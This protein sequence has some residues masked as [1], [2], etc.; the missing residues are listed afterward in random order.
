MTYDVVIVGGGPAGLQA[1]LT[2]GRARKRVLLCDA[3]PR[4]N[5]AAEHVHNFVTRD[6]TPPDELRGV[7]RAQLAA[8]PNVELRDVRVEAIAGERGAF[9][10]TLADGA[11]AARRIVLATGMIDEAPAIEGLRELWGRAIFQCPYCHGWEVQDRRWG[12]LT[13]AD[14]PHLAPFA[15]M[16][17]GWTRDVT[18]FTNGDELATEVRASLE[19]AGIRIETGAIAR[20]VGD[21]GRLEAIELAG[22]ARVPCDA[23][24]THPT[25]RQLPL[26]VALG[27]ALDAEGY[28]QVDPMRRETSV[29]GIYAAGDLTTRAQA[30]ILGAAGGM[31]AAAMINAELTAELVAAGAI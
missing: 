4:R 6:G 30:A 5:A 14:A 12:F 16:V 1:A 28:V 17:R 8:Y 11:I 23:L 2:L 3:G 29:P 19:A 26:V 7:A 22:G 24:F 27:V 31:Q 9:A 25:Q 13:R 10:V 15:L 18:V 21:N 20:L